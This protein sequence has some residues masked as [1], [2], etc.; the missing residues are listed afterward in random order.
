MAGKQR[1]KATQLRLRPP[2]SRGMSEARRE[3]LLQRLEDLVL[4]EGFS[5]LTV[6]DLASRLQCSKSTL[7]A[8]AASKERLVVAVVRHFFR[9][10]TAR[11]EARV[12]EI[13]DPVNRISTYLAS[14]GAEM[15]RMS[16]RCYADMVGTEATVDIYEKNSLAAARRVREFIQDGVAAGYFRAV[17]AEFVGAAVTLLIDGIQHGDLL[18]RTGLSSG[19]AYTELSS[20]VLNALA[21]RQERDRPARRS[22]R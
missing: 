7:Y 2:R 4:R 3:D 11:I 9:E 18:E 8:I 17:N 16:P 19:D 12:A 5:H 21:N 10:A 6:D 15:R 22:R 14:V 20:L 13:E 1:V